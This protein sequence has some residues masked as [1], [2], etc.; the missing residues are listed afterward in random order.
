[1]NSDNPVLVFV[2]YFGGDSG[3]W[4]WLIK[5]LRKKYTCIPLNLPGFGNSEPL[6]TL[7]LSTFANW[8]NEQIELLEIENYILIGHS[9][10]GKM[11][12]YASSIAKHN[13]PKKVILIAPSPPTKEPMSAE[14]KKRML[15]HPDRNESITSVQNAIRRRIR[16]SKFSYAVESQLKTDHDTWKW[17]I[18]KGMNDDISLISKG[19]EIPITVICSKK[20]PVIPIDIIESE[21]LTHVKK[22]ELLT[23][24][25][26]GHLLPLEC[27]RKLSRLITKVVN[28]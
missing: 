1:M 20:D 15:K 8:I 9:M 4:Q 12:L 2:H 23:L 18:N 7:S 24:G 28:S 13:I 17:W 6:E 22:A 11:S 26:S 27:P 19:S 10:G 5:R 16:P 25:R 3:S 14:E 21:V